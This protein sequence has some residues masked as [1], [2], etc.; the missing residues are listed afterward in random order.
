MK[1][2]SVYVLVG[3]PAS[4]KS[5][6]AKQMIAKN[7]NVVRL[8]RDDFRMSFFGKTILDGAEEKELTTVIK[9][10]AYR[11][12]NRGKSLVLDNTHCNATTLSQVEIDYGHLADIH[13]IPFDVP[14]KE[15]LERNSKRENP[16][17]EDVIER[18]AKSF[19]H[20]NGSF[21][22][23]VKPK[24]E[25]KKQSDKV[26]KLPIVVFDVDN[27][28]ALRGNRGIFDFA[29]SDKDT[30]V[31]SVR[32][33]VFR[34][35]RKMFVTGRPEEFREITLKWLQDNISS[36]IDN[37]HLLMRVKGDNRK[38]RITKEDLYLKHIEPN[39]TVVEWWD[40]DE[41]V[42]KNF[43]NPYGI[44]SYTVNAVGK[45]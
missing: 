21:D 25:I 33:M 38:S 22:F 43:L 2:P 26:I 37:S 31:E 45:S 27:T 23:K 20:I 15:L 18:M 6:Y 4:G 28:L 41:D 5:T 12:L 17:P 19:Y 40:D 34:P 7:P 24:R 10:V 3:A 30:V 1:T 42:I 8:N 35:I 13:Y 44:H 16:V 32:S 36:A 14:Y 39:Y 11:Y 29:K 9:D